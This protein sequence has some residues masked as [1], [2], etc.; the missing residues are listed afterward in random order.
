MPRSARA[1]GQLLQ[2]CIRRQSTTA[3]QL[4][5]ELKYLAQPEGRDEV[6]RRAYVSR[7]QHAMGVGSKLEEEG[8]RLA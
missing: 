2:I 8:L 3:G 7:Q 5:V 4:A 6:P 1:C